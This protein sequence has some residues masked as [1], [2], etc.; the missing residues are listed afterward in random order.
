MRTLAQQLWQDDSGALLSFEWILLATILVLAMVVGVKTVQQA[1][2]S[3]FEDLADAIC[4]LSQS[5]SFGGASIRSRCA[6][7]DGSHFS[8]RDRPCDFD[9]D[10]CTPCGGR[11]PRGP[12]QD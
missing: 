3:E 7:V 6:S 9:I 2:L 5:Y 4:A 8:R 10:T 1:V 12:C 11:G